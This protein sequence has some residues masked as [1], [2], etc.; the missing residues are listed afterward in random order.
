MAGSS[1]GGTAL[2]EQALAPLP[3]P[4]ATSSTAGGSARWPGGNARPLGTTTRHWNQHKVGLL[5]L[6]FARATSAYSLPLFHHDSSS[7]L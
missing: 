1:A 2:L 7:R 5:Y 4:A 3:G 6:T